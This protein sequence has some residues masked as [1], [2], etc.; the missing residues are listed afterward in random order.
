MEELDLK[1]LISIF[2]S[3]KI[4]I[5]LIIA[6][7]I[8][9]GVIYTVGFTTPKYQSSTTLVLAKSGAT[10]EVTQSTDGITTTDITLNSKLVS[11]YSVIV[12][13]SDVIR[14]VISNLGIKADEEAVKQSVNVS[15]V[16]DTEV[17]KITVTNPNATDAAKIANEIAKV[18]TKKVQEIYSINNVTIL[19]E[20]EVAG[21]PYN[22]NHPRDIAM[23]ALVGLVVAIAYVLLANMLDTT[24]KSQ[25]D[26]EKIFKVPV[27][28]S[29]P[30]NLPEKGGRK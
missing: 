28:A 20:A 12:K 8:V 17:I 7:F 9:I 24:I 22:I 15:A 2:W 27:L 4:H 10:D 26:V 13:S 16:Q 19:D 18:F 30:L 23:F 21:Q 6:I 29:I 3:K 1:E 11:T 14:E 25:E 5:V